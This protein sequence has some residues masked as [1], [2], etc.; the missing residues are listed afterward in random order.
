VRNKEKHRQLDFGII[1]NKYI[2]LYLILFMCYQVSN[3]FNDVDVKNIKEFAV[4]RVLSE[5]DARG[6]VFPG[7][8]LPVI[9]PGSRTLDL[10]RWGLIPHWVKDIKSVS[11][12]KLANARAETLLEKP[13]FRLSFIHRRCL[14]LASGFYEFDSLKQKYY[15]EV[16][17]QKIFAFAGLWDSWRDPDGEEIKSCTIITCEPNSTVGKVHNRMPVILHPSDYELWLTGES[18]VELK[19]LLVPYSVELFEKKLEKKEKISDKEA[20]KKKDNKILKI[21]KN[22]K[23]LW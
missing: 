12:S 3:D 1:Q 13:S 18:I 20:L 21:D 11:G 9:V 6:S 14:V 10:Y 16:N 7:A 8:K 15:Y 2:V 23:T 5:F 17:G 19:K 4:T 22:Q